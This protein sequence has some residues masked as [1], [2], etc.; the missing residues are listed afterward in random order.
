MHLMA[1]ENKL[2]LIIFTW[3]NIQAVE[4][5]RTKKKEEI[6]KESK[7]QKKLYFNYFL[8]KLKCVRLKSVLFRVKIFRFR[9][10]CINLPLKAKTHIFFCSGLID[11][12]DRSPS[13]ML[14]NSTLCKILLI[15]NKQQ[16]CEKKINK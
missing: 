3:R 7:L 16:K 4:Q 10:N 1:E 15:E 9:G 11:G 14:L 13:I 5:W 8:T 6:I 12:N 2:H